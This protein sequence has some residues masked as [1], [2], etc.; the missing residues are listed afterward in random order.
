MPDWVIDILDAGIRSTWRQEGSKRVLVINKRF[1]LSEIRAT[2]ELYIAET[3]ALELAKPPEGERKD[4]TEYAEDV[5]RLLRA[6]C[7]VWCDS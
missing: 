7:S 4:V 2:D 5:N 3:A 6:F 1:P